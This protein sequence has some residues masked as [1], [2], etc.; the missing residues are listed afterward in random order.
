MNP[1]TMNFCWF[2]IRI[3]GESRVS[4]SFDGRGH[5][6]D[7]NREEK[8]NV[9]NERGFKDRLQVEVELACGFGLLTVRDGEVREERRTEGER[10]TG[11]DS[12]GRRSTTVWKTSRSFIPDERGEG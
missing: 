9:S 10:R 8:T 12:R 6:F 1:S 11:T 5:E 4:D 2:R 7:K 3:E